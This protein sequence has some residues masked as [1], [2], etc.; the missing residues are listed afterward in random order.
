MNLR[1]RLL[2][3]LKPERRPLFDFELP[4]AG[5]AELSDIQKSYTRLF[6]TDD[7]KAVLSHLQKTVFIRA[8]PADC[9]DEQIRYYEGQRALVAQIL[10]HI[11]AGQSAV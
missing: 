6:A 1:H 4:P 10:R 2:G 5:R 3:L 8:L 11:V 9:A 7:G